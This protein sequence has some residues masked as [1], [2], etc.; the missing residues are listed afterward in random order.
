MPFARS[1][2]NSQLR[3]AS[4]CLSNRQDLMSAASRA[5]HVP[6]SLHD[7]IGRDRAALYHKS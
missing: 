6:L 1:S 4:H 2:Q 7:A 5:I 3:D